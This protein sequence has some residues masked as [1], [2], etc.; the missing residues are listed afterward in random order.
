M[1]IYFLPS[2]VQLLLNIWCILLCYWP[3]NTLLF[4][5]F[6]DIKEKNSLLYFPTIL[7]FPM[8]LIYFCRS[9]FPS[10]IISLQSEELPLVFRV[11]WICWLWIFSTF[12]FLNMS[13][14]HLQFWSKFLLNIEFLV[15]SV[16]F[17]FFLFQQFKNVIHS[18]WLGLFLLRSQKLFLCLFSCNEYFSLDYLKIFFLSLIFLQFDSNVFW[19]SFLCMFLFQLR[20]GSFCI[21]GWGFSLNLQKMQPLFLKSSFSA[22]FLSLLI[23][24]LKSH[25]CLSWHIWLCIVENRYLFWA[26]IGAFGKVSVLSYFSVSS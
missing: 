3:H 13:L 19:Y 6:K 15:E 7:P 11:V 21:G 18:L 10:G 26:K 22:P 25:I 17:C 12:V 2:S 5:Y 1:F 24:T 14:F 9:V 20:W 23:F 4:L 16:L 8:F